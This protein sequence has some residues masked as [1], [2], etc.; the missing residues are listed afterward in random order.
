MGGFT[1]PHW[2]FF[3]PFFFRHPPK[4]KNFISTPNFSQKLSPPLFRDPFFLEA[5]DADH[6]QNFTPP[7]FREPPTFSKSYRHPPFSPKNGG[8]VKKKPMLC[9]RQ[10]LFSVGFFD[11]IGRICDYCSKNSL[12]M[13]KSGA[14]FPKIY[15]EGGRRYP[16]L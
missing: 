12:Q 10:F 2:F 7:P 13:V 6:Y 16:R 1:L 9:P 5:L 14:E 11:Q 4:L 8:G 3:R 15:G